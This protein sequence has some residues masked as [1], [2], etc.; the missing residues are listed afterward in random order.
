MLGGD[1]R[2]QPISE[3][4]RVADNGVVARSERRRQRRTDIAAKPEVQD[5]GEEKSRQQGDSRLRRC[6]AA[7]EKRDWRSS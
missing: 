1:H 7:L 6:H 4:G 2:P 5:S 3:K